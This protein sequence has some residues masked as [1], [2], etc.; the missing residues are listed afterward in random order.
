MV[1]MPTYVFF[2]F[3]ILFM[4]GNAVCTVFCFVRFHVCLNELIMHPYLF[5]LT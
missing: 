2:L 4:C 3:S 1:I 5:K